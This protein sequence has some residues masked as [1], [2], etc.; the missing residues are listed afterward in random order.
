MTLEDIYK[1]G[2]WNSLNSSGIPVEQADIYAAYYRAI[3]NQLFACDSLS[4][5]CFLR[6]LCNNDFSFTPTAQNQQY[7]LMA[8]YN[9]WDGTGKSLGF[10]TL[11]QSLKALKHKEL[12]YELTQVI[13]LL[14][15]RIHQQESDLA[16][17]P[18]HAIKLHSRYTRQQILAAFGSAHV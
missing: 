4:Y 1:R 10:K 8:H 9:F 16:C 5:L 7:A 3:N 17:L 13:T 18:N 14:I 12:Q 2:G 15:N 11:E 6:N